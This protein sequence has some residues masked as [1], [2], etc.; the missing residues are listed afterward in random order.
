MKRPDVTHKSFDGP[1]PQPY[2]SIRERKVNPDLEEERKK[3]NFDQLELTKL[4][5]AQFYDM[6]CQYKQMV[7]ENP[8]MANSLDFY[9]MTREEQMERSQRI[10]HKAI[11]TPSIQK[12]HVS[13]S[14][15]TLMM[16]Y[17]QGQVRKTCG[18]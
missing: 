13:S 10:I 7:Q 18:D 3:V 16:D 8:D 11:T 15:T 14:L 4:I 17:L 6:H 5:Y 12:L 1:N 9:D 2:G